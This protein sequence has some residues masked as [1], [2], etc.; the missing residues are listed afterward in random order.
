MFHVEHSLDLHWESS[1]LLQGIRAAH[2]ADMFHV[3]HEQG[4]LSRSIALRSRKG[5]GNREIRIT[6]CFLLRMDRRSMGRHFN[7][8]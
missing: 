3:E 8:S 6:Y 1:S 7:L 5:S 4:L 2:S